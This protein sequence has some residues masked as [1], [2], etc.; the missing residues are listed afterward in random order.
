MACTYIGMG[1]YGRGRATAE[2]VAA[3]LNAA[4]PVCC[5]GEG[6]EEEARR[7]VREHLVARALEA[8]VRGDEEDES[9]DFD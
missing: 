3:A 2:S 7:R 4:G 8:A 9:S 5:R 6:G 1:A